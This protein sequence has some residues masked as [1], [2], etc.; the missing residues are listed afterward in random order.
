MFYRVDNLLWGLKNTAEINERN[1]FTGIA[2]RLERQGRRFK[3]CHPDL[4]ER[5][6]H[7]KEP[8]VFYPVDI[9][10]WEIKNTA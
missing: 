3:S 2:W 10:L 1:Y 4:R 8:L 9:L 5:L 7:E 6:L